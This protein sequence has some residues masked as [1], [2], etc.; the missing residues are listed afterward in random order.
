MICR[1]AQRSLTAAAKAERKDAESAE[2]NTPDADFHG[3]TRIEKMDRRQSQILGVIVLAL[4]LLCL[5]CFRYYL[6]LG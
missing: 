1:G 3:G 6:K 2:K 4:I 5:A